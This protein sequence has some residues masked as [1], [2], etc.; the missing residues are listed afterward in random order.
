MNFKTQQFDLA[1]ASYEKAIDW[2]EEGEKADAI[3]LACFS[4]LA[5]CFLKLNEF[6]KA[7]DNCTKA[8]ER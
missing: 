4:N 7:I 3:K 5:A 8:L 6:T 1:V 2:V